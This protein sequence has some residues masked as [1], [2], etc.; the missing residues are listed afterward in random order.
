MLF[1]VFVSDWLIF[2]HKIMS[3]PWSW[4]RMFCFS[5]LCW[6]YPNPPF[7]TRTSRSFLHCAHLLLSFW[8]VAFPWSFHLHLPSAQGQRR[9]T[10]WTKIGTSNSENTRKKEIEL[11]TDTECE[12]GG[13]VSTLY[14]SK[15]YLFKSPIFIIKLHFDVSTYWQRLQ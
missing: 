5:S 9:K 11:Q 10:C 13:S 1:F 7:A 6:L 14:S 8:Y 4:A 15:N 2:C 3:L 12:V